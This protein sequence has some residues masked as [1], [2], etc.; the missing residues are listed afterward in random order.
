MKNKYNNIVIPI[1]LADENSW[2]CLIGANATYTKR[3]ADRSVLAVREKEE[4]VAS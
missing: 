3:L 2:D 1:D 4:R